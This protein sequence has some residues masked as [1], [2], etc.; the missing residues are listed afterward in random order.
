[1]YGAESIE[2]NSSHHQAVRDAGDLSVIGLAVDGTVEACEDS[3]RDFCLGVQWH[4]E[5]PDRRDMDL[6]LAQKFVAAAQRYRD[7]N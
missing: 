7:A 2:V 1:L 3:S 6:P 4:P 5:H